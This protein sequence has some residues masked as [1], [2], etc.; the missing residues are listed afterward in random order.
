MKFLPNVLI[1]G[2]FCLATL[3]S[4]GFD[5]TREPNAAT[6]FIAGL[7]ILVVGGLWDRR[8]RHSPAEEADHGSSLA[9][10]VATVESIRGKIVQ[11]DDARG[12]LHPDEIHSRIDH[13]LG[14]EFFDLTSRN[15][16]LI[17]I[18]GFN[19]Y[20]KAWDGVATA[21]RL[22]ARCWSMI[23]D[24]FAE[25]GLEELP[26][27]RAAIDQAATEFAALRKA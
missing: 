16:E 13:L 20:A 12:T 8:M 3:G 14:E 24:G 22:L 21:E 18:V 2:G 19:D 26:L 27:A 25:E 4:A 11:L 9:G 5:A 17:K 15:E 7:A 10:F 6:Y 1:V 23:T